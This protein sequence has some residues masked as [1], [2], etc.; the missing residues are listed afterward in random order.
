VS[1]FVPGYFGLEKDDQATAANKKR[2]IQLRISNWLSA[3]EMVVIVVVVLH[4]SCGHRNNISV[5]LLAAHS[6][7]SESWRRK[8]RI[9]LHSSSSH[10]WRL[11]ARIG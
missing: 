3:D 10:E 6:E 1:N 11:D 4:P 5:F 9:N 7:D 2:L 8:F